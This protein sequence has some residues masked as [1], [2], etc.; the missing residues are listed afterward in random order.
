[1]EEMPHTGA[2]LLLIFAIAVAVVLVLLLQLT[3][4]GYLL[5]ASIPDRQRRRMFLAS[6]AFFVTF[7]G[8]RLLVHLV[9]VGT[10]PFAWVMVGGRHI[11]HLVWGILILLL[12]GY[13]W[14]MD[15][16]RAHTPTGILMSRIL[17]IAY[18]VGAALTLDEFALWLNLEDV[19]WAHA[20]R[21]SIDAVVLF[22]SLL[23]I[24]T[25]GAPFFQGL[26]RLWRRGG[27]VRRRIGHPIR[28]VKWPRRNK[29]GQSAPHNV[30]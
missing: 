12:V 17:S 24:G 7:A 30:R 28:R 22:G 4:L 23:M 3:R 1:M 8:V 21:L 2:Y 27:S 26:Q 25:W 6:V 5:R 16:G 20:G 19:Y 14:L 15:L 18:G 11:H 9:M 13:G 29:G 10:G